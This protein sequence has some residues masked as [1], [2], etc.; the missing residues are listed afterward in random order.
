MCHC[1]YKHYED[2]QD[3][4][5]G[6]GYAKT[7]IIKHIQDRHFSSRNGISTCRERIRNDAR[8]F[9]AWEKLLKNQRMWLCFP[10]MQCYSWKSPC[11]DHEGGV[12]AGPFNGRSAD[13]LLYGV[14]K[15]ETF[16]TIINTGTTSSNEETAP[17]DDVSVGLSINTL[18]LVFK[19]Q[20]TTVSSI[21]PLCRLNFS[22]SLNASL[23]KVLEH[24]NE[25]SAWLELLLLPVCTLSLYIPKSS[26]EERSGARKRLQTESINQA[27]IKWKEPNGCLPLVQQLLDAHK[28]VQ[29]SRKHCKKK[30]KTNVEACRKKLSYG[31]YTDAIRILSSN[32]VAPNN[33]DTLHELQ[34][35]HPH[36]APP[37]IPPGEID[38]APISVDSKEVLKAIRSFPKGTSCGRDG[39]RA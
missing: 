11:R 28:D 19:K 22:R 39:L 27:L 12:L 16:N 35:K 13:F 5:N 23:D 20:L 6:R 14:D 37:I 7:S 32:G 8:V 18:D 26:M 10:C 4:V 1:P 34:Q 15:P 3:G 38:C 9:H 33:E 36:A 29:R 25:V 30:P 24:P 31:H 17:N 21:P 2:C